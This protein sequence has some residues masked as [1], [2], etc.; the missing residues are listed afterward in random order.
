MQHTNADLRDEVHAFLNASRELSPADQEALVTVFVNQMERERQRRPHNRHATSVFGWLSALVI[1]LA[2]PVVMV[3][4]TYSVRDGY[5]PPLDAGA[6]PVVYWL[7]LAI[8][9]LCLI[10]SLLGEWT[11]WR[12]RITPIRERVR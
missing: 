7:A 10:G 8:V 5:L 9:A 11:G 12:L 1:L 4:E 3:I 2:I 6:L